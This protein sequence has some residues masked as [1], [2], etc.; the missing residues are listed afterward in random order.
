[1]T[2]PIGDQRD[3][4]EQKHDRSAAVRDKKTTLNL[5]EMIT[6]RCH[7]QNK[8][9][10]NIDD[11]VSVLHEIAH[12]LR[13]L[14][15]NQNVKSDSEQKFVESDSHINYEAVDNRIASA[16]FRNPTF[17]RYPI[18]LRH[19][20]HARCRRPEELRHALFQFM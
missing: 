19:E 4:V 18:D 13:R 5:R 10:S 14:P 9:K 20:L 2:R 16:G 12:G 17:P 6:V 7:F 3:V 11:F 15:S 1:M 8:D